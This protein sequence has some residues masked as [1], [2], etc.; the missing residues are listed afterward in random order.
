MKERIRKK[1]AKIHKNRTDARNARGNGT[2]Y[3]E[4]RVNGKKKRETRTTQKITKKNKKMRLKM[5]L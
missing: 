4:I 3:Q 1:C 5:I 2:R